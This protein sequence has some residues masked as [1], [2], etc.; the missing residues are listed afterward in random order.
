M[1]WI[2][3]YVWLTWGLQETSC[4]TVICL[5]EFLGL[6]YLQ[7]STCCFLLNCYLDCF[8]NLLFRYDNRLTIPWFSCPV[9]FSHNHKAAAHSVSGSLKAFANKSI[10]HHLWGTRSVRANWCYCQ[11]QD[12]FIWFSWNYLI[13]QILNFLLFLYCFEYWFNFCVHLSII[14]INLSSLKSLN[15]RY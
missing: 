12:H 5:G 6:D 11:A 4:N 9:W 1:S 2:N 13:F 14:P 7:V 8:S 10:T 3:L 15:V